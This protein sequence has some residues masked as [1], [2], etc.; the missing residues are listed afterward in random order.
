M[1]SYWTNF[2]KTGNPN[3]PGLPVWD[4]YKPGGGGKVMELGATVGLRDEPQR[5][6]YE[7]F[8]DLSSN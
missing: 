5:A 4:A 1:I 7:F 2:A 6:R 3:G 8:R